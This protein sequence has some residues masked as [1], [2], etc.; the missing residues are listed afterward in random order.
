MSFSGNTCI[1]ITRNYRQK[2]HMINQVNKALLQFLEF[3]DYC[4]SYQ[5]IG[6]SPSFHSQLTRKKSINFPNHILQIHLQMI[7]K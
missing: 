6:F 1:A 2:H 5:N 3:P 7:Q 4:I